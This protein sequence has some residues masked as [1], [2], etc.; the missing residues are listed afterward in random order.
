MSDQ[1]QSER[2]KKEQNPFVSADGQAGSGESPGESARQADLQV[3]F[4]G[5][6]HPPSSGR[7]GPVAE[8][9]NQQPT[10]QLPGPNDSTVILDGS[11]LQSPVHAG[12][13][14]IINAEALGVLNQEQLMVAMQAISSRLKAFSQRADAQH[15]P[16]SALQSFHRPISV[17]SGSGSEDGASDTPEQRNRERRTSSTLQPKRASDSKSSSAKVSSSN[18]R[19]IDGPVTPSRPVTKHQPGAGGAAA[20]PSDKG[21][22]NGGHS[23]SAQEPQGN[24]VPAASPKQTKQAKPSKSARH[25]REPDD[26]A[27]YD[28]GG[29]AAEYSGSSQRKRTQKKQTASDEDSSSSCI[30]ESEIMQSLTGRAARLK[31]PAPARK[32][33]SKSESEGGNPQVPVNKKKSK[34][35]EK[36]SSGASR[37]TSHSKSERMRKSSSFGSV[38]YSQITS[39]PVCGVKNH[40]I[41][42]DRQQHYFTCNRKDKT[43]IHSQE[44]LLLLRVID[45]TQR[46]LRGGTD[47]Y[48]ASAREER[49][50]EDNSSTRDLGSEDSDTSS[51]SECQDEY[52]E[53]PGSTE[54]EATTSA[55]S[56]S[57][58]GSSSSSSSSRSSTPSPR[59]KGR[60]SKHSTSHQ[61]SGDSSQPV[62]QMMTLLQE[63]SKVNEQ[64]FRQLEQ[65][66][67]QAASSIRP[68][69]ASFSTADTSLALVVSEPRGQQRHT[70]SEPE[71]LEAFK[72]TA[73]AGWPEMTLEEVG[74]ADKFKPWRQRYMEYVSKCTDRERTPATMSQAFS[75]WATWFA[76]AFSE[77]ERQ[78]GE[79]AGRYGDARAFRI[80]TA[81]QVLSVSDEEFIRRYL[82][83]CQVKI[84]D[85]SQ[86]LQ[87]LSTP[88]V[89]ASSGDLVQLMQA[90]QSFTEQLQLIPTAALAQCSVSQIREA[91]IQSIFGAE[92][93][94]ERKVDYLS[95]PTWQDACQLMIRKA[96][97]EGG[98]AFTP[99]KP[100]RDLPAKGK[101]DKEKDKEKE[102][103][104]QPKSSRSQ[105]DDKNPNMSLKVEMKWKNR[106]TQ[107]AEE[108]GI[109]KPRHAFASSW[110][111]R[112]AYLL[113][114]I[115]QHSKCNRCRK[116]GHLP[117]ACTDPLPEVPYP[118][119]SEEQ[120]KYLKGLH[121]TQYDED[122]EVATSSGRIRQGSATGGGHVK[123]IQEQPSAH[124][125]SSAP[126]QRLRG[127]SQERGSQQQAPRSP[128]SSALTCYRC[129][130]EGHRANECLASTH[131]DGSQL[132]QRSERSRS[133][134][135]RSN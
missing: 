101:G 82:A 60:K 20:R 43:I 49:E 13:A 32:S 75:K 108:Y 69:H 90:A 52:E 135:N 118:D 133:P 46:A 9:E 57:G 78:R 111:T 51:G 54:G 97:G 86:V 7:Q 104:D 96:S 12:S 106:F 74:H 134:S 34:H 84:K 44:A 22:F 65:L 89:D 28:G 109:Q 33:T 31:V 93:F 47:R 8:G 37:L 24:A 92:Q 70:R 39:C 17:S 110:K 21:Q 63:Q 38:D 11:W 15:P 107:L 66:V 67:Q 81:V 4:S 14:G 59:R 121:L 10:R 115:K 76:T 125:P 83:F 56:G 124:S 27:S 18:K 119:L 62:A 35:N 116:S 117:S 126:E 25:T 105:D 40:R 1:E 122:G 42:G 36:K 6:Q 72:M 58:S 53:E 68:A 71:D 85:P 131:R 132:Q 113:D 30:S 45:Q 5:S 127:P 128:A 26:S 98:V 91:F 95:C 77:Q 29:Q 102:K 23:R 87:L 99:F 94:R 120:Q 73:M 100:L 112:Y 61:E 129:G 130:R 80:I 123:Q 103:V 41:K 88:K 79:Q 64:R 55:G 48:K 2:S 19:G 114:C 50:A 3:A 16:H